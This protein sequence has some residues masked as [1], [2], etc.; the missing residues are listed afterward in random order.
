MGHVSRG[1]DWRNCTR[2]GMGESTGAGD[3]LDERLFGSLHP[4]RWA[5]RLS[6]RL[7]C[8]RDHLASH[9]TRWSAARP[10][11][12]VFLIDLQRRTPVD[13][14]G[15]LASRAG[16]SQSEAGSPCSLEQRQA[17]MKGIPRADP[18][19]GRWQCLAQ[20]HTTA[21]A[22]NLN[23]ARRLAQGLPSPQRKVARR[24]PQVVGRGGVSGPHLPL[25]K[26]Q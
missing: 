20:P 3:P 12:R 13:A 1:N 10:I 22:S 24:P 7:R 6:L 2:C 9:R 17:E 26:F 15:V 25:L 21:C 16:S 11:E 23:R 4:S 8:V 19:G 14:R 5:A 18:Q